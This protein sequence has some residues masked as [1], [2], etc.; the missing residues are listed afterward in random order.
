[1]YTGKKLQV[2][3]QPIYVIYADSTYRPKAELTAMLVT[4]EGGSPSI[5]ATKQQRSGW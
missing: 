1:M 3:L 2:I 5:H 4:G